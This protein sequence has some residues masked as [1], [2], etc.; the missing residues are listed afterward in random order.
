MK[1]VCSA[2]LFENA[3]E[4]PE[5]YERQVSGT[6]IGPK[7]PF[8]VYADTDRIDNL[9]KD[10]DCR[11]VGQVIVMM[12]SGERHY[13][14]ERDILSKETREKLTDLVIPATNEILESFMSVVYDVPEDN[15]LYFEED[16]LEAFSPCLAYSDLNIPTKYA[17][18]RNCIKDRNFY[19]MFTARHFASGTVAVATSCYNNIY[20][21]RRGR[22]L[23][24]L[25]NFSPEFL[26]NINTPAGFREY[27]RVVLHEYFHALGFISYYYKDY[28]DELGLPHSSATSKK[29]AR[30]NEVTVVRTP[31][32]VS[33]AREH[34]G[35]SSLDGFEL[36]NQGGEGTA[37]HHWEKRIGG[38]EIM[39]GIIEKNFVMSNLTL[40]LLDD[41]GFYK[42]D[43]NYAE[44]FVW[45]K[46]KGCSFATDYC[47]E[48]EV[49][50]EYFCTNSNLKG[51]S[52]DRVGKG[53][54]NL[55]TF[56][57][58]LPNQYRYFTDP[59]A[60]GAMQIADY[61]P[62]YETREL[63]QETDKIPDASVYEKFDPKARCFDVGSKAVCY[64]VD[65]HDSDY[66]VSIDQEWYKCESA[67]Q[68]IT[69]RGIDVECAE[70]DILCTKSH[71]DDDLNDYEPECK[72]ILWTCDLWKVILLFVFVGI[73]LIGICIFAAVCCCLR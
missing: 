63:C 25:I 65:C 19:A 3:H 43:R 59:K 30:G 57:T 8:R 28:V 9:D 24:G 14:R 15:C 50:D 47:S 13:C 64:P 61:C 17:Q 16:L 33:F 62:Y 46:G 58:N 51:C 4:I 20:A 37:L 41:T 71:L 54:C 29:N 39:T 70:F 35:C 67:G 36:E 32:V 34:F 11:S 12:N 23:A 60:G 10:Y 68:I 53:F 6:G 1:H 49:D 73:I 21:G 31:N 26:G 2:H 5:K 55:V 48:W 22:P 72:K 38:N 44:V 42:T 40:S 66:S 27:I 45:G 69:V 7:T 56:S 52:Y 18:K